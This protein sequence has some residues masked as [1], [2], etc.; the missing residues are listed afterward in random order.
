MI[1]PHLSLPVARDVV[2][3]MRAEQL[4]GQF[5]SEMLRHAG[6]GQTPD[7][8]GG[9]IGDDQFASFLRE[10]QAHAIVQRGGI[11]LATHIFNALVSRADAPR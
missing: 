3:R 7:G 11:G 10:A 1:D 9:G 6:V 4:E 8:F 5:L 2:L